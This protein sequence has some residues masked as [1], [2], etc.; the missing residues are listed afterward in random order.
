MKQLFRIKKAQEKN[1]NSNFDT[2]L[3]FE[4]CAQLAWP[5]SR[6]FVWWRKTIHQYT[7]KY[8]I[9]DSKIIYEEKNFFELVEDEICPLWV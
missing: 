2:L 9:H 3:A 5:E 6:A 7:T 1:T 4:I 8:K